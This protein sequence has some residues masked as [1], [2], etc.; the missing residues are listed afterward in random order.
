[1]AWLWIL[2]GIAA[3][4]GAAALL[5]A[6]NKRGTRRPLSSHAINQRRWDDPNYPD[7]DDPYATITAERA[8]GKLGLTGAREWKFPKDPQE[9]AKALMPERAKQEG[10]RQ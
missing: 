10:N 8:F 6:W 7:R 1:M 9:Q 4:V 5:E 2:G 3:L